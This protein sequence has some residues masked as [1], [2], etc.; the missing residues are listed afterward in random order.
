[1]LMSKDLSWVSSHLTVLLLKIAEANSINQYDTILRVLDINNNL[2]KRHLIISQGVDQSILVEHRVDAERIMFD[3]SKPR[4][5]KQCFCIHD[6]KRGWGLRLG[7]SGRNGNNRDIGPV[8]PPRNNKPRMKTEIESQISY[9]RETLN[10][11]IREQTEL[12]SQQRQTTTY[13]QKCEQALTQ[14]KRSRESLKIAVQR[15]DDHVEALQGELDQYSVQDG[16][17]ESLRAD[18]AEARS[19]LAIVQESYGNCALEKETLNRVSTEKKR[20]L[21]A[22]KEHLVEQS[23]KLKKAQ[24]N[25][26][27]HE[28]ARKIVLAQKNIAILKIE[29]L[30]VAKEKAEQ[31]R[32]EQAHTVT[33][34]TE[35]A[36]GVCARVPLGPGDT[37]KSLEAK[38][39]KLKQSLT[40]YRKKLGG[41]DN[42][43]HEAAL[44][45]Q[46]TFETAQ[47]Y[48]RDL[49][50]LLQT[51][52]QSFLARIDM[53]RRFQKYISARSR[54]NFN[55][56]LSE[57]AFRGKLTIDH[58]HKK[59]D[60]HVEPD[61][62][63]K[64]NKGRQTKTLSGGEKSFSSI[65]LLL[66]LW[67][68]MGAPL[69]CLDEFDV[70]MDDINRD[71]STKMIV[72]LFWFLMMSSNSNEK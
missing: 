45:A 7:Y 72:S 37:R 13:Q 66:A 48:H 4:N 25:T 32:A 6:G 9:Q 3:G 23:T 64:G 27:N 69:R 16:R 18:L 40:E 68:A 26:K 12:E 71:V 65:C 28:Q 50:D 1:M 57:R 56:L 59:L 5:V 47:A 67:E 44:E 11:L 53:F 10:H 20:E 63:V 21:D 29:E 36:L 49:R 52:K 51:L 33:T 2:V 8:N 35:G 31:E 70:F 43:I 39:G 55:Y 42:Q 60:V 22:A 54:I 17:L 19:E 41:D 15:A 62:T 14:N 38:L 61:E 24:Q 30:R 58:K 34:F 46:K